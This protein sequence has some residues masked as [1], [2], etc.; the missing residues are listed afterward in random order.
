MV[1]CAKV[2]LISSDE[3]ETSVLEGILSE[4]VAL[5]SVRDLSE[6]RT[7]LEE[8][9]IGYDAL[10]CGWSF[11]RGTWK[12]ALKQVQQRCPNLPVI[13]FSHSAGEREWLEVMEAGGFDL[14]TGPYLKHHVLPLVEHAVVS[15]EAR[16]LHNSAAPY[17]SDSYPSELTS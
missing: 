12:E 3:M 8:E 11:H 17:P 15:H 2:L 5:K 14:L 6:L 10:F 16:R 9:D 4:H 1:T 7:V 13:I